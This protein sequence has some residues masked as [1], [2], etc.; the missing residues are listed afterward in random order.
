VSEP[1]LRRVAW[2]VFAVEIVLFCLGVWLTILLGLH[3]GDVPSELVTSLGFLIAF[4]LLFPGLGVV[5][6]TRRPRNPLGWLMLTVGFFAVEPIST[7]G[8]Y[9]LETGRPWGDWAVAAVSW[10]WVPVI[11]ISGIFILLLFPDGRLPSPRWRWFAKVEAVALVVISLAILL[12]PGELELVSHPGLQNPFGIEAIESFIGVLYAGLLLIPLGILGAAWSLVVRFR[13]SGPTERLQIRW[14][15]TAAVI[16]A[17]LYGVAMVASI[18]FGAA[19]ESSSEDPG[20]IVA[21]QDVAVLSFGLL[22]LAIG[23]AV[24]RYRLYEIDVVIRKAVIVTA[25]ALFFTAVY[26]VVVGGIGALVESRSTTALS[27]V[28]AAVVAALFQPVLRRA[29]RLADRIVYGK[30]ATPYEVLAEFSERVGETY[31]AQDVLPRMARVVTEAIGA[32]QTDVWLRAGERL[33][34]AASWP[35]DAERP[36]DVRADGDVLPVLPQAD[37]AFPVEDRGELLGAL[38]VSMPPSEPMDV[39]KGKLV[40]DL[41]SQAGLVLRNVRLSEDLRQRLVDLKAAQKRLVTAQDQERRRLERNIHDG[42]QQ[43][44]VALS[45]QLRLARSLIERDPVRAAQL[46]DEL[47]VRATEALDDLR[48]LARGIYPPLLADEGLAS[49]IGAQ[50][51]R[52]VM[53]VEVVPDGVGR[54]APEVEAAVYFSVLEA[55]QNVA[56]YAGASRA[57]VRLGILD[58]DLVFEVEDDGVGFDSAGTPAGTGLRGIRDRLEAL[59]GSLD[60]R[61]APGTGTVV[62]GRVPVG[63]EAR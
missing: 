52:S 27:F 54:Y 41:A 26:L 35:L 15:A 24:L 56:K 37:A 3:R 62:A 47:G 63:G 48:D 8:I 39:A 51:R 34:V 20:W 28:S 42:A 59:E 7:Y 31:A 57:A 38:T 12:G 17:I 16:V 55:L 18:V 9:A 60:V 45:V 44:L 10:T 33:R 5:L 14:L 46:L 13:R 23:V 40:G 19:W 49:A 53:P 32:A 4:V 58:G 11:G 43:Q 30:R 25:I 29:R 1:T 21:L 50:A 61:S 6:A 36:G 2:A 22:P